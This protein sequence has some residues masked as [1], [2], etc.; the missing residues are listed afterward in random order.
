MLFLEIV[1]LLSCFL[2]TASPV[3]GDDDLFELSVVH[4]NDFHARYVKSVQ[5]VLLF[6][7]IKNNCRFAE[8][9]LSSGTCTDSTTCIGGFS[10][11]Y[12]KIQD[13]LAENPKSVLLNGGDNFQGTLYYTLGKWNIT[14]EFMNKLPFDATVRYV[15]CIFYIWKLVVATKKSSILFSQD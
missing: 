5:G 1:A 13:M 10:R 6:Q 11:M 9:S 14:Q 7:V 15:I 2:A 8:T 12:A 4:V 3:Y